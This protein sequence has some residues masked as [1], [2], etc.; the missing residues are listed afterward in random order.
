MQKA[1]KSM[2]QVLY[3]TLR[4][5]NGRIAFVFLLLGLILTAT[6]AFYSN[7][8]SKALAEKDFASECNR[9][10]INISTRL[11]AQA[12]VLQ[13]GAAFFTASDSVTRNDWK[14]YFEEM[15]IHRNLTAF[16]GIGFSLK[17]SKEQL[18]VHIQH[19]RKEGFPDYAVKPA[20]D[21]EVYTSIIYLEPFSGRNLRAFGYDMF[22]DSIRRKA[23]EISCDLDIAVLT[24]KVILVQETNEAQQAGT[25]M[26]VPVYRNGMPTET[27]EQRRAAIKGWV[28]SPFR[29]ND[30]IDGILEH[31]FVG[32]QGHNIDIQ[33]YDKDL[34][35]AEALLYDSSK[36]ETI[37]DATGMNLLLPFDFN[38]KHWTLK[39]FQPG[40][41]SLQGITIFILAAGLIISLLISLLIKSLYNLQEKSREALMNAGKFMEMAEDLAKAQSVAHLGNWKWNVQTG[42]VSWSDEMYR[43]FGIDKDTFTGSLATAISEVIHPDDLHLVLPS[44][45]G[46]FAKK[47]PIEYRIILPDQS[48]RY[49]LAESGENIIDSKGNPTYLTGVAQDITERKLIEL[50]LFNAK[51][52]LERFFNLVPA[53]VAVAT[54]EGYLTNLNPEWKKALGYTVQEIES[55]PYE[56]FIH[57]DDIEPTRLEV[58]RQ[59]QGSTTINFHNRYRHKDGTYRWLEW[60]ATAANDNSLYAAASDITENKLAQ[61][62]LAESEQKFKVLSAQLD[63]IIDHI[64]GLVFYKDK[65]NHFIH[66]NKYMAD[67]HGKTKAELEG[68]NLDDIYPKAD[69]EK[70]YADD[71]LVI[72]SGK[73]RLD[74]EEP[75][76]TETGLKWVSSSKIPF[77]DAS[78]EI[79]G[80][81]GMSVDI[82]ERK[83]SEKLL[84]ETNAYLEN[85]INYANAPIIVWDPQFRITRFNHAFEFMTG[86]TE[87]E[88]L[89]QSLEILFP[90]ELAENSME[91]IK[92]TLSGERWESVEIQ[93]LNLDGSIRTLLWN[94]A[95]L[96]AADGTIP[97]ATIAQGLDI[98]R[99]LLSEAELR[100]R[101]IQYYQLANAGRTL[102]WRAGAD[103]L[104]YYFNEIWLDFTGRTLEQEMG[105]GWAEGVHPD[106]LDRCLDIYISSFDKREA[107][108]MEYRLRHV[109]GEYKW[110]LD[111]GTPNFDSK[112]EFDGFIGH[113]FDISD[114]KQSEQEILLKNEQLVY[115]SDEKDKFFS[116]IAHD[117]RSPFN[118]FLGLTKIMVEEISNMSTSE[119]KELLVSLESSATSLYSLLE[120]LLEWAQMQRGMIPF[121][122]E[123]IQFQQIADECIDLMTEPARKKDIE[124]VS[125][126]PKDFKVMVDV[127]MIQTVIRNFISNAVKFTN[128]GGKISISAKDI[129]GGMAE[130]SIR[131]TG[132]GMSK[133]LLENLFNFNKKT[134]RIGTDG[135][136]S[137]G[138]GLLLCNEF[139]A[140]HG[141]QIYAESEEG[142]GSVF[143]F[144]IPYPAITASETHS[145]HA[146][147]P[148]AN[149][150]QEK[151]LKILI[152]EDDEISQMLLEKTVEKFS[153]GIL[154]AGT[155]NEAIKVCRENP[156]IDLILM[157]IHMPEMDGY[158]ATVEIR[159]F[160]SEVVIFA[161]TAYASEEDRAQAMQAGCTNYLSKP[162]MKDKFK[163][164][165]HQYFEI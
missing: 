94:S 96:F 124:I 157:D 103:K 17:I 45:A 80:V 32:V 19:L 165:I 93:I 64:P 69:S 72:N 73:A 58:E 83:Q 109:S 51:D 74:I 89:G 8:N 99:R 146:V 16:Q 22:S 52:H 140:K 82:T 26:Y 55:K 76:E 110:L 113:C 138:L 139:V 102:I 154:K 48:I 91:L 112:G 25:L 23:M 53:L 120:N 15:Q 163:A 81:I 42:E 31:W 21:R 122:P 39:F 149:V 62:A 6:A 38:G 87:A 36:A 85:L 54:T 107:F 61:I 2:F 79:V 114:R 130:I 150:T 128:Q 18:P 57:P 108:E 95:T 34:I 135:E 29:M 156:D 148:T 7:Q 5:K 137:N 153:K 46:N 123:K 13:S 134:N 12:L 132:I 101:E 116:I 111:I 147:Q 1:I 97:V 145:E 90:P 63:A 20:G 125:N 3:S 104:C 43:I 127:K 141:G 118:G 10:K 11:H 24:D 44:N 121:N 98:T 4:N 70:Y 143:Y 129:S 27:T 92:K 131:D 75:W 41:S 37:P 152:A 14:T 50:E 40:E 49:I 68:M 86:R 159:K 161:Q 142:I 88:V 144:T 9:I 133:N 151:R 33:I 117:L 59:L 28:Y 56:S 106:D 84:Y 119:L 100:E 77:V 162:I 35:S 126:I 136:A 60:N 115:L 47:T 65:K 155:G 71:L 30:L 105:N 66:V 158:E 78:G 160:N 164:L 67:A